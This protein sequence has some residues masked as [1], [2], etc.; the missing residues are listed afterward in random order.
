[1]RHSPNNRNR[2]LTS[3]QRLLSPRAGAFMVE[4]VVGTVLL[5][6]FLSCVGPMFRWIHDAKR[7]SERHL[8]AMQELSTQMEKLAALAPSALTNEAGAALAISESTTTLLPDSTMKATLN[9]D[10]GMQRVTLEM[11]WVNE[12]G[13]TVEPRRLTA[14]F[15]LATPEAAE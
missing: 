4:M 8:I 6:V 5:G 13:M 11:S 9:T 10:E 1:M 3:S 2:M 12:V 7:T 15:P 14:W